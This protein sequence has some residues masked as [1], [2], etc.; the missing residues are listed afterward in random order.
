MTD[1][2]TA[3]ANDGATGG[4]KPSSSRKTTRVSHEKRFI[5]DER[6]VQDALEDDEVRE[7][8]RALHEREA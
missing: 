2:K 7:V 1:Q 5:S 8:L 6:R 3:V 4:A